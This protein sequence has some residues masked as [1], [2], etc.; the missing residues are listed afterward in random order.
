M[1]HTTG[2][3]LRGF[4]NSAKALLVVFEESEAVLAQL[5][6]GLTKLF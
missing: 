2:I 6:V 3:G 5:P 4:R 1:P